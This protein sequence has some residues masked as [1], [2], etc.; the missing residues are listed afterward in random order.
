MEISGLITNFQKLD[1][2]NNGFLDSSELK[3]AGSNINIAS[4]MFNSIEQGEAA[5]HGV[6]L[7]DLQGGKGAAK[8]AQNIPLVP[9]KNKSSLS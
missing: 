3:A 2:D 7:A 9:P 8:Q 6:S 4:Y 5:W 1:K